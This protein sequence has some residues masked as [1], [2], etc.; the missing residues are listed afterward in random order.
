M[1]IILDLIGL[2]VVAI[3]GWLLEE[4]HSYY[5]TLL[6]FLAPAGLLM[7]YFLGETLVYS[8][9]FVMGIFMERFYF[10]YKWQMTKKP[11]TADYKPANDWAIKLVATLIII[12]S[13]DVTSEISVFYS[14]LAFFGGTLVSWIIKR[15]EGK[16]PC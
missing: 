1:D 9:L 6:L 4:E 8:L 16:K 13:L 11:K 10:T 14:F 2:A 3:L 12:L 5:L 15:L 7:G